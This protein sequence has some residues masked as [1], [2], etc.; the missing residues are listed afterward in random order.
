MP[1]DRSKDRHNPRVS[2]V[3]EN[4]LWEEL[5]RVVG[6]KERSEVT[7]RLWA[8]FLKRPGARI[9]RRSDYEPPKQP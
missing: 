1:Q 8:A 3:N 9:P 5:G 2:I 7:R 4:G 6:D